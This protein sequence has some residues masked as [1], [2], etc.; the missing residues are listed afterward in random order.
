MRACGHAVAVRAVELEAHEIAGLGAALIAGRDRPLP[1]LLAIDGV[2]EPAAPRLGAE[3]AEQAALLARQ[4]LDRL[5]LVAVAE[6]VGVLE[7]RQ[8]RQDAVALAERGLG[9]AAPAAR[10]QHQRAGALALGRVPDGGLGDQLAVLVAGDDLQHRDGGQLPALLEALA[11]AGEQALL[12]HL[13]EQGLERDAVAALDAEGARDLALAG[14]GGGG[15]QIVE[16]LLLAR[17][18]RVAAGFFGFAGHYL[19]GS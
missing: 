16:D 14:L 6:D 5:G 2:D 7:P 15:A 9:R 19:E 17:Q 10:G 1:Q 11:V 8:P 4:A 3:D 18:A 12:G 13:G